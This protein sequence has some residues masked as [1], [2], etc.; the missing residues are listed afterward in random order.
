M[1]L[2]TEFSNEFGVSFLTIMA[3]RKEIMI[4][5]SLTIA[6][7]VVTTL[8]FSAVLI[9]SNLKHAEQK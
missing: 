6:G 5:D 2:N 7:F 3:L 9:I 4:I 1:R 8:I